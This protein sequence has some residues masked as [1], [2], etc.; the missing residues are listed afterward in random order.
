[1]TRLALYLRKLDGSHSCI[2]KLDKEQRQKE[3]EIQLKSP[4]NCR[5]LS[6]NVQSA[7]KNEKINNKE[8]EPPLPSKLG[9]KPSSDIDISHPA[10][11]TRLPID[12]KGEDAIKI[13]GLI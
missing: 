4:H 9:P 12:V 6:I 8:K 3:E 5:E 11:F 13:D 2:G 7:T 1:V 10:S